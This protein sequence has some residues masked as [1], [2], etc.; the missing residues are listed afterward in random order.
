MTGRVTI[1]DLEPIELRKY[2]HTIIEGAVSTPRHKDWGRVRQVQWGPLEV[3]VHVL[4]RLRAERRNRWRRLLFMKPLPLPSDTTCVVTGCYVE[5]EP[6]SDPHKAGIR[7][8]M[9]LPESLSEMRRL[10]A[11]VEP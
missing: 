10:S 4:H 11:K 8:Q 7:I 5:T 3:E 1:G 9:D 2:T 6:N